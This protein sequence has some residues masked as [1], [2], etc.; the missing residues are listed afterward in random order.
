[1]NATLIY[2]TSF[3]KI[4]D[5]N[6]VKNWRIDMSRLCILKLYSGIKNIETPETFLSRM[7]FKN[8]Y[9][10]NDIK[11]WDLRK[12]YA[13]S[14]LIPRVYTL[15]RLLDRKSLDFSVMLLTATREKYDDYG[16]KYG[17]RCYKHLGMFLG[18]FGLVV[19]F[20]D[21]SHFKGIYCGLWI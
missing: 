11:C 8:S 7:R 3:K 14:L 9:R 10:F 16:N 20:C 17:R 5:V 4:R 1:M 12:N 19:A 13:H 18:S 2:I 21:T 15:Y 6:S